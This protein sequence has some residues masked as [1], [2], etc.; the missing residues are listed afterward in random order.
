MCEVERLTGSRFEVPLGTEW[1]ILVRFFPAEEMGEVGHSPHVGINRPR[2]YHV[3][4]TNQSVRL[5][6]S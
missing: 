2:F 4:E 1:V 5:E 6:E 3:D